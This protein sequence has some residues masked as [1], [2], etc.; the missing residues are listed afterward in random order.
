[1]LN[2]L[3][4][5]P[6]VCHHFAHFRKAVFMLTAD[7]NNISGTSCQ[8]AVHIFLNVDAILSIEMLK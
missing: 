2:K 1:M 4:L 8:K 5:D 3:V 7:L 6:I